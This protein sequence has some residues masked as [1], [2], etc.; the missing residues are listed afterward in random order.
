M[1]GDEGRQRA[2]WGWPKSLFSFSMVKQGDGVGMV[3]SQVLFKVLSGGSGWF[4]CVG[5]SWL[6]QFGKMA[7]RQGRYS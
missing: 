3:P 4:L 5:S 2:E 7:L 6:A 1:K